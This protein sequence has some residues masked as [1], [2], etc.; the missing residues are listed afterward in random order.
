MTISNLASVA[1]LLRPRSIAVVGAS[2]EPGSLGGAVLANLERFGFAGELHL[3]SRSRAEINGRACVPSID[4]LPEGLDAIVLVV[5]AAAVVDAVAACARRKAGAAVVFASGFGEAGPEGKA[6]QDRL[7]AIARDGGLAVLGPNCLGLVN[8]RDRIPLT[9]ESLPPPAAVES[10]AIAVIAQ[11]GAMAGTIR[12]ALTSRG[13]P[14][15][16]VVSTG[17]EAVLSTEDILAEVLEDEATL[18]VTIFVEQIRQPSRFRQLAARARALGKPLVLLHP[19]RSARA[20]TAAQSHT[21]ALAG[22]HAVMR[23]VLARDAVVVVDTLDELFDVTL[24]LARTP[25]PA[26][27]GTAVLSNSGAFC[28]LALD[29]AEQVGLDLPALT[30]A[31]HERLRAVLPPLAVPGNPLDVTTGGMT[32]PNLF[33]DAA[34]AL[35]ADPAIGHL[36]VSVI[37]GSP[38]QQTD[39]ARSLAPVLGQTAKPVALVYMGDESPIAEDCRALLREH[40]VPFFRS[41]DRALRAMAQVAGH[42]RLLAAPRPPAPEIAAAPPSAGGTLAEYRGKAYLATLGVPVPPSGLARSL[43][44]A[45]AIAERLGYPVVLKAQ[46]AELPHK[47]EAGGV[48]AGIDGPAA[49]DQAWS[50]LDENVRRARPEL[51]LD[52]VLVEAMAAKGLEMILGARRDPD[53]GPILLVGLG[54]VM[55]EALADIRLLPADADESE[56]AA[57][58]G[59]LKA[60]ALLRGWRGAP[61]VDVS[62][63][64]KTAARLGALLR[65]Q[66]MIDELEINPLVAYATGVLAL[67]VLIVAGTGSPSR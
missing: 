37:G 46:S 29:M 41:P 27:G 20:R 47:T 18:V 13:L 3:V 56:I 66:P 16:Y 2:P 54:G 4:D 55:A 62:A 30:P 40:G 45:R 36:V 57:E 26:G 34:G 8:Y 23:T 43:T 39:K 44:E 65:S 33:G 35:L 61:A 15:S 52:G 1:G 19:G 31:T 48:I 11:S 67:D 60:A 9:F 59:K 5:P 49:L 51:T 64:A 53:W 7:I 42:G 24:L 50:R 14:V 6:Q 38:A 22:D 58:I 10:P 21:G 25:A 32:N 17:N 12:Y 63:V 28:G